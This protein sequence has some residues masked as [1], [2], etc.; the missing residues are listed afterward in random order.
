MRDHIHLIEG[1]FGI[2]D[3]SI[4]VVEEVETSNRIEITEGVDDFTAR[5]DD[6]PSKKDLGYLFES[7]K[8]R[9]DVEA[10]YLNRMVFLTKRQALV[11]INSLARDAV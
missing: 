2:T 8:E 1:L 9:P 6:L 7:I 3:P 10:Y 4:L 5:W 11:A